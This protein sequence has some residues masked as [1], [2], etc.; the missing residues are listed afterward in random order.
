[1]DDAKSLIPPRKTRI[2]KR[3]TVIE[4]KKKDLAKE[5][6]MRI[7]MRQVGVDVVCWSRNVLLDDKPL[8]E[9]K[10]KADKSSLRLP[11]DD[12]EAWKFKPR[13]QSG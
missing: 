4:N 5:L 12:Q 6:K 10:Y 13:G 9:L 3:R 11:P 8:F 1:M 7:E 2:Q